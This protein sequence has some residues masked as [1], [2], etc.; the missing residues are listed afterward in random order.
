[1]AT[2]VARVFATAE[3]LE[4]ILLE[5]ADL[6]LS[7]S[8]AKERDG[9]LIKPLFVKS[10]IGLQRVNHGFHTTI[11][12]SSKLLKKRLEA[13]KLPGYDPA[14]T[15]YAL[16]GPL[17]WLTTRPSLPLGLIGL[18]TRDT[19]IV[20]V[21]LRIELDG[22]VEKWLSNRLE[23]SWHS[24]PCLTD[25]SRVS[26]LQLKVF[27]MG[28]ALKMV[29]PLKMETT[30]TLGDLVQMLHEIITAEEHRLSRDSEQVEIFETLYP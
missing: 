20:T 23:Q 3:L 22:S 16:F 21:T 26:D 27:V 11:R 25:P 7:L 18:E 9:C 19:Q 14:P 2:A 6:E 4:L 28:F 1:M 30:A 10:V 15:D 5:V 24:I 29:G 12:G 8:T 13:A 17:V